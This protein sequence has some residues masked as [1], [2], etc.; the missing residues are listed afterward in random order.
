MNWNFRKATWLILTVAFLLR[1]TAAF[2]WHQTT[3]AET[4]F[5]RMGDSLSYWVL[6]EHI[7]AGEAYEYGSPDA[8]IFRAPLFPLFLAPFTSIPLGLSSKVLLARLACAALGTLAVALLLLFTRRL[9]GPCAGLAAGALAAVYPSAI[10]MSITLLSEAVFMPLMLA[11]LLQLQV[12][13]QKRS[14]NSNTGS[15]YPYRRVALGGCMAGLAIL[16]RPSWLLF[17]PFST[18]AL[19]LIG[20]D[21]REHLKMGVIALLTM[22]VMMSPWWVRNYQLTGHFVPTSLQ[23]GL[24]LYDGLHPEATG[25][26]DTGM[27]FSMRL[28][29]EQR[30]AD[31]ATTEPLESTFE[32]RVDRRAKAA[33]VQYALEHP[34][35]TVQ[36]AGLKFLRTWSIWP[37][38]EENASSFMRLAI[39]I[40]CIFVMFFAAIATFSGS[41]QSYLLAKRGSA[42]IWL[43]WLPCIYFTLLHMVFVGSIR[44]REPAV[45]V[46]CALAGVALAAKAGCR[47]EEKET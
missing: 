13:F 44:Y 14:S 38:G 36:L 33:A 10:G 3:A 34:G 43:C 37:G 39:T 41:T 47:A 23:V 12:A 8:S 29:E 26:S 5:F 2:A 11:H 6:A 15:A 30:V 31:A 25:G 20:P 46:L 45:F 32:Y 19:F 40:S 1:L 7:A 21:R 22:S 35:R 18:V 17:I 42:V 24:S 9:A 28:Q 27:A 4:H 16:A